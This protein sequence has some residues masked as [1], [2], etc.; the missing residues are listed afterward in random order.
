MEISSDM[1]YESN[2][3]CHFVLKNLMPEAISLIFAIQ[4]LE[5][6]VSPASGNQSFP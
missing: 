1:V 6:A 3:D 2:F 4:R 5:P